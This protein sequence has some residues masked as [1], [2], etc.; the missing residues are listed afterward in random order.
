MD[1]GKV[2]QLG[3]EWL[4][5][6]KDRA[7][8]AAQ[9]QQDLLKNSLLFG[10]GTVEEIKK[11]Q[12]GDTAPKTSEN[13]TG[14]INPDDLNTTKVDKYKTAIQQLGQEIAKLSFQ[15]DH[16]KEFK[17]G[18]DSAKAAQMAFETSQ[19][20]FVDMT[21]Q[22]KSKLMELAQQ[23]DEYANKL[24]MAQAAQS[25]NKATELLMAEANA[26]R[27]T[28]LERQ[29]AAALQELENAGIRKGT[30]LYNE[31]SAA[32]I[33]AL[34]SKTTAD[35]NK[36]IAEF[37][38]RSGEQTGALK[39]NAMAANLSTIQYQMHAE[40]LKIDAQV[41]EATK[42]M[43]D[44]GAASFRDAAE[45]VKAHRL[46]VMQLNYEQS[47]TF[48][49][50]MKNAMRTYV[51]QATDAATQANKVFTD[52]FKGMEDALVN[53]VMTGKLNFTSLADS[54]IKDLVR[55]MVQQQIT[56]PLA[57]MMGLS[58][59]AGGGNPATGGSGLSS[60]FSSIGTWASSLFANGGIMTSA[61]SATLRRYSS[62]G[63]ATTPQ[64]AM[65]GEGSTPEAYVPLPDGR[66]IPVAMQGGQQQSGG[67]VTV[68]V[69]NNAGGATATATQRTDSNGNRVIDVMIEQ[70]KAAIAS[71]IMRGTGTVPNALERTYGASRAA[72]AY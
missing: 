43:T 62:G 5:R 40:A 3:D 4:K 33:K 28:N 35:E 22:Q 27:T 56:G 47:R 37:V 6:S 1:W 41:A 16:L 19:G 25:Y 31:L 21:T 9:V 46:E 70:V 57:Q 13:R 32:R 61:G 49:T 66:S 2:N 39:D 15:N 42:N 11:R 14:Q 8:Q 69:N 38:Q 52:A 54:I 65:F 24:K 26:Q 36:Q 63:I 7:Q 12:M 20:Q 71:D 48:D 45:V 23:V 53:F 68:N 18:F 60:L 17:D 10:D 59:G 58:S 29:K 55:M 44:E 51:E 72:G 34:T 50:G 30:D 67:N 64:L